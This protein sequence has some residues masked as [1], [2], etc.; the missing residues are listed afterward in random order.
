[1]EKLPLRK[2]RHYFDTATRPVH[3]TF[4]DGRAQRRNFP[5]MHYVEARW[6]YFDQGTI[7]VFIGD[8]LVVI[9]GNNLAP[10][11]LAIEEQTLARI[12]AQPELARDR[13]H[14]PDSFATE[15]RFFNTQ[16]TPEPNSQFELN[17][18]H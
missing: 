13:E 10:L 4:D 15:I 11:F 8:L 1:M 2:A 12:R 16:D 17:L 6:E 5:W 7:N 14:E 3:V 9:V 18:G